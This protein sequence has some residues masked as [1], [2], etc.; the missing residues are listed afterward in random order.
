M[1]N[2]APLAAPSVL[3]RRPANTGPVLIV[4]LASV[5]V[6][7]AVVFGWE[8][9]S[10]RLVLRLCAALVALALSSAAL[11]LALFGR[12]ARATHAHAATE[13]R[14]RDAEQAIVENRRRLTHLAH[15]DLL[16]SLPNR[17]YLQS[18]LPRLLSRTARKGKALA[19]LYVDVD[20]FKDINDSR[21]HG[22]GDILLRVIAQRLKRTV[23]TRDLVVR[24][25]GD[26]FVVVAYDVS[27]RA[28]VEALT[29][30]L[31]A[32]LS[33]PIEAD[34]V[35]LSVTVSMGVSFYPEDGLDPEILL[36]HADIAL[37]QAKDR[38]RNNVQFFQPDMNVRLMERVA[39]E[40]ALRHAL[41][42]EQFYVEYQ[43]IVNAATGMLIGL[44]ALARWRHP[45]MGIVPP[46]RFIP[47]AEQSGAI[48][49]LGEQVLRQ[50]CSQLARWT[51]E[52]LPLVPISINVSP[53]QFDRGRLP[54]CVTALTREFSIDPSLL[55]LEI[56]ESAIMHDIDRHLPSLQRLRSLGIKIAVDDFGTGYSSLSYLKHLPIDALK[57]DRSFVRDMA[58]DS[59]DAAIVTAI[60][61]MARTL[62]LRTVAEGV[63]T[64][65]QLEQLKAL[66]C[67][68]AQGFYFGRPVAA[69]R[70]RAT[71]E[72]LRGEPARSDTVRLRVL[73]MVG[74]VS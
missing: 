48:L 74:G 29:R 45:E 17:P 46:V 5:I 42:T 58:S 31:T 54:D 56:T 28:G 57:I 59:N 13:S 49:E 32:A 12:L 8:H 39:L 66:G 53:Q 63:E 15:H 26:E 69:A 51:A 1:P 41:G 71:V 43:P 36:K 30:R 34:D 65:E 3:L 44:E 47:V 10:D 6:T 19:L 40:Q 55:W 37:Y 72:R 50:V 27:D 68:A 64:A 60:V 14:F 33:E 9:A 16:T 21:G 62:K 73:R 25:G 2:T 22:I 7:L 18:R 24:M 23:A 70:Y 35:S 11:I 61:R 52:G 4:G 20:H 67:D 38:G